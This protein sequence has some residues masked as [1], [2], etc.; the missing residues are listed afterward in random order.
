[1][2]H[3]RRF[4]RVR[5][6][7]LIQGY[8]HVAVRLPA[9]VRVPLIPGPATSSAIS[10]GPPF[11]SP[12]N[13]TLAAVLA[14]TAAAACRVDRGFDAVGASESARMDPIDAEGLRPSRARP[15]LSSRPKHHQAIHLTEAP[16]I[17]QARRSR[18]RKLRLPRQSAPAAFVGA[19]TN[20][21]GRDEADSLGSLPST[22]PR[23]WR[24]S[25]IR[26][27]SAGTRPV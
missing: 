21:V 18:P 7:P 2:I 16:S 20:G 11:V 12:M 8:D 15:S 19:A 10:K 6:R 25:S 4:R 13:E 1:M 14:L 9:G 5:S 23:P 17:D 24:T 22:P 26:S 3:M 27:A